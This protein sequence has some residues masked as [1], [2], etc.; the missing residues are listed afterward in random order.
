[1]KDNMGN[2]F[3]SCEIDQSICYSS[4][5]Q[6]YDLRSQL[7][8][9]SSVFLERRIIRRLNPTDFFVRRFDVNCVPVT[10]KSSSYARS[11]PQQL[12]RAA[13]RGNRDHHFLGDEGLIES[14]AL[15]V[16]V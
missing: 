6:L 3:T 16:I 12:L 13:T 15:A 2:T 8:R 7:L 11:H 4:G 14:F 9:K 5:F 10:G 1:A